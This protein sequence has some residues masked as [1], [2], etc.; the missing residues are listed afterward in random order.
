[1]HSFLVLRVP[2]FAATQ[3]KQSP[4]TH[5]FTCNDCELRRG[6]HEREYTDRKKWIDQTRNY[7][8]PLDTLVL[9]F[10]LSHSRFTIQDDDE[11]KT[12]P[13]IS[14]TSSPDFSPLWKLFFNRQLTNKTKAVHLTNA[15]YVTAKNIKKPVWENKKK[16]VKIHKPF[17]HFVNKVKLMS[18]LNKI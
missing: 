17:A 14:L 9:F 6:R 11:K 8:N 5:T 16:H 13:L 4:V 7:P 2:P 12:P 18:W 3:L 15:F 10:S 1:M